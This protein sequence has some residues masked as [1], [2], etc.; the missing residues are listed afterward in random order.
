ML[1]THS[2]ASGSVGTHQ[3]RFSAIDTR[4][5]YALK[6]VQGEGILA[7]W[8]RS[9]S[10]AA[11]V[12]PSQRRMSHAEVARGHRHAAPRELTRAATSLTF[13]HNTP[14][15]KKIHQAKTSHLAHITPTSF[16]CSRRAMHT[17]RA[18]SQTRIRVATPRVN[19]GSDPV[20]PLSQAKFYVSLIPEL[21]LDP[22]DP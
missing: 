12:R 18:R 9:R 8:L 21:F 7:C 16:S 5:S 11:L 1:C 10:C 6:F 4:R 2:F 15:R 19:P 3:H 17:A 13:I 22:F 20:Q 14:S